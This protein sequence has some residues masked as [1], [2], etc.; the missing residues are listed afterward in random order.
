MSSLKSF[1]YN[2]R[3][4]PLR[5]VLIIITVTVG[6]A[7]LSITTSLSMDINSALDSVL[8]EQGRRIVIANGELNDSGQYVMQLPPKFTPEVTDIITSG[9][10]ENLSDLTVVAEAWVAQTIGAGTRSFQVRSMVQAGESYAALMGLAMVAGRFFDSTD[11]DN[12]THVLIV[13]SLTAE[14]LFGSPEAALGQSLSINTKEGKYPYEILGV[15]RD[16]SDMEREA[17]G[18]GDL[19][20]PL[21]SGLPRDIE[22]HP[23]RAMLMARIAADSPAKA[24][25]RLRAILEPEYGDDLILSIWEGVPGGPAPLI[26]ESRKSVSNFALVVSILGFIILATSSIGIF[27]VMLVIGLRRALGTTRAGVRRYFI[28]QALYFSLIGSIVGTGVA[29]ALYRTIGGFLAPLFDSAGFRV[30]D[31]NLTLPGFLP[32]AV[33]VGSALVFGAIFGFFPAISA[34]RTPIVECI[35]EDTA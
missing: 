8:A 16:V 3:M 35:R 1:F 21:G 11:V 27:S 19:I 4:H 2:F 24:E 12:R 18:I 14:M 22:V 28:G 6:V 17:Y 30:T 13:S 20:F 34:A 25:S 26:E 31:I 10:Y 32:I 9:G 29:V 5:G 15:Y 23:L 7:T 33:A